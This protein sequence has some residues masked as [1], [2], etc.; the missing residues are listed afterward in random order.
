[1]TLNAFFCA[2][3]PLTR[4]KE[5]E[6]ENFFK[7]FRPHILSKAR[8]HIEYSKHKFPSFAFSAGS[9]P[10]LKRE[11]ERVIS[12][13]VVVVVVVCRRAV[14]SSACVLCEKDISFLKEFWNRLF[15]C[16]RVD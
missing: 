16:L 5:G 9:I 3:A 12:V 11:R 10:F 4:K 1:M 15:V 7:S 13:V 2:A 14:C 8:A 6:K